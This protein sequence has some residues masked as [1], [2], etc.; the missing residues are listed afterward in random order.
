M[1]KTFE[2]LPPTEILQAFLPGVALQTRLDGGA[3]RVCHA[4]GLECPLKH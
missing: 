2:L 4:Q 1:R 3:N